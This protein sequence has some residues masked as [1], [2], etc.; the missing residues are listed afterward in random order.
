MPQTSSHRFTFGE[1]GLLEIVGIQH[2]IPFC[3]QGAFPAIGNAPIHKKGSF[4]LKVCKQ[5]SVFRA[6]IT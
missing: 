4:I 6:E 3:N 1:F 2:E 5:H